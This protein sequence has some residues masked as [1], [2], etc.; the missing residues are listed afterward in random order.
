MTDRKSLAADFRELG[1]KSGDD[2]FVHSSLRSI[3]EIDGGADAVLLALRDA[4]GKSGTL[5]FP[6]FTF[7]LLNE[8][9]PVWSYEGSPSCVGYLSERFRVGYAEGRSIHVSHSCSAAGPRSAEYL[10]H[11]L[12]V[13]PCGAETP[14]ARL[15]KRG[16]VLQIGCSLNTLT[17]IHVFEEAECVP[18][19]RFHDMPGAK[20]RR[21]GIEAVLP[22]I[23]VYPFGYDFERL[24]PH[25]KHCGAL[26]EG[27]VGLAAARLLNGAA[28]EK[29]VRKILR[30][31]K[32]FLAVER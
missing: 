29:C 8:T 2:V 21:G 31:D 1:I 9:A 26:A 11:P 22:S 19:V 15:L 10:E 4:V 17:A 27:K 13:T 30:M 28:M 25:L 3:G 20:Y 12:N 23:V 14:L 16:K 5:M 32:N 24:E 18:Y 7:G 6:A